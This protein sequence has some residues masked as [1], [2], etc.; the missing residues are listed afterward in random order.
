MGNKELIQL[1][2]EVIERLKQVDADSY[3]LDS[4]D[5]RLTVY[6]R[7]CID[8][9]DKH[10]LY[11]LLAVERFFL[12]LQKYEYRAGEVRKFITL[13]E[14]LKFSGDKGA[15]KIKATPVQI[16]QFANIKGFYRSDGRRLTNYALLFVPRKFGKTTETV[17]FMVDDLLFGD[18]NSQC[19]AGANSYKQAQILFGEL[20]NV[21]RRL[22]RRLKR[23]KI[24][25]E[26]ITHLGL[27]RTSKAGCLA[28]KPDNL[29]GLNASLGIYDELS[30]ADS[31]G[32]KNVIDSSMGAR[33]NPLSIAITTASD[34]RDGPFVELLNYYKKIL[35]G[36]LEN[37][38]VFAHIFEPDVDD[39][40][41]DPNTW[42]KVQPHMGITVN[43][44]FYERE[45]MVA[46]S[47]ADK[48]KEFR[49]KL[50]NVFTKSEAKEWIGRDYIERLF[51]KHP[52]L[53]GKRCVVA[54]D[55]SV[56]DDFSAVT[57]LFHLGDRYRNQKYCPIHSV[58]EYFI[59]A[60]T[61]EKHPNRELYK[62]WVEQG[63][64]RVINSPTIDYEFLANDIL[65]HPYVIKGLGYD[66]Y[67]SRDFLKNFIGAGLED[68]LYPIKQTY[69]ESTSYV[70][71]IEIAV[72]NEQMTFDPNPITSYCFD[73]AVIDEDRLENRKP[74]KRIPTDK[75]DGAITNLMGF[76]MMHNVKNI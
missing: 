7:D 46:Q 49:N 24:N 26:E 32:L 19:Y 33:L 68:Y 18:A 11:E 52:E 14:E 21:L 40:E 72:F 30:N 55:L 73:N 60:E 39:E 65:E 34:K 59:P 44:D 56:V 53:S 37:D 20:K 27:V 48:M 62:K 74:I 42:R 69:G 51:Y 58:T 35:R 66:P 75:I 3:D 9:P 6:I 41:S 29:D 31:F 57:Y 64:L 10:N 50:L 5:K 1:K 43:E 47:S 28:S 45:L 70:E 67:K 54:V 13:F 76:W 17:A 38:H 4:T 63:H 71:A 15:T 2:Q 12:F 23:F 8:N 61:V 36:E 16:F 25:R 22:D